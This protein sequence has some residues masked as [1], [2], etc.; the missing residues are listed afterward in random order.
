MKRFLTKRLPACLLALLL[1]VSLAPGA[2]AITGVNVGWTADETHHWQVGNNG[3]RDQYGEHN[4][5]NT[6]T[7]TQE[8]TCFQPGSGTKE[9]TVCGGSVTITLGADPTLHSQDNSRYAHDRTS[10]W[11][12]CEN[13][14]KGCTHRFAETA[15]S[16][17]SGQY[18]AE[19][20]GAVHWQIC[21]TCGERFNEESHLDTS[22]KD[23]IC[24][25][26][27]RTIPGYKPA[28]VSVSFI[29]S[30]AVFNSQTVASGS[31]PAN[32]GTPTKTAA[33]CTYTFRG[34]TTVDPGASA[35]Y[36]NQPLASA[37]GTALSANTTY[38]A[39][40]TLN[41]TGQ[42]DSIGAGTTNGKLIG[43]DIRSHVATRFSA[44][45]GQN[46][47]ASIRFTSS[48]GNGTLYSTSTSRLPV[49]SGSYSYNDLSNYIYYIP[50]SSGSL[51]L[52][53]TA[54]DAYDNQIS[55][56]LTLSAST[57]A[58]ASLITYY[59]APGGTVNFKLTDFQRAYQ[60]LSGGSGLPRYV[61]FSAG[62]DYDN[63]AGRIY[64]GS[65]SM[66]RDRVNSWIFYLEDSRDGDYAL[67]TLNFKADTNARENSELELTYRI[68]Y[69]S[70]VYYDGTLRIVIDHKAVE[71]DVVYRVAPGDSI[72]FNR[73]DF[74]NAYQD[75]TG[76]SRTIRYVTFDPSNLYTNFS[77]KISAA[78]HAD[79]SRTELSREQ[80]N[81]SG[82]SY[83][84]YALDDLRFRA[85]ASA[86]DGDSL[87]IDFRA[88]YS[89]DDYAQGTL[90]IVIDKYG[91]ED[92]VTYNVAPGGTVR[93]DRADFNR[94][95]RAL[96]GTNNR[97]ITAVAFDAPNTYRSFPGKLYTGR[98]TILEQ[99]ELT[100]SRTWFYY[101]DNRDGDF[102]LEDVTFQAERDA[103][104]GSSISIP[105]RAYY[106]D[107]DTYEEGTLRINITTAGSGVTY[108][109]VPGGTVTFRAEDFNEAYRT[110]SGNSGRT[111]KYIA[112]EANSDYA[113]FPGDM[114]TTNTP[115]TRSSLTYTQTQFYY[116]NTAYGA[117]PINS[118]SF[119][120]NANAQNQAT[121]SIPF[122][123]YFDSNSYE[124]STLKIVVDPRANGDI[125]CTVNPGSTVNLDRTKFNDFYRKTY[126]NDTFSYVVFEVPTTSDFASSAGTLYTGYG[127][128]YS[129]SLAR[130]NLQDL[131]FYYNSADAR[132]GDYALNDLTFAAASSFTTGRV[133]L[134][135]TAYGAAG[136]SVE[137]T[138][139]ITPTAA[140][141]SSSYV[142]SIRYSVASGTNVQLNAN[143]LARFYQATY[144]NDTL[145]YVSFT[146]VPAV[147]GLY[148]NYYGA[149]SYGSAAQEQ[150]TVANRAA[151]T[152]YMS[153]TSPTQYALTELAYVPT[154]ANYCASIPFT[155]YGTANRSVTGAILI[156]VTS[157]A[158]SEV[159]G[160]TPK[161]V[162]VNFPASSIYAAVSAASGSALSGI[163][164][165][166]LPSASVGVIYAG[167]GNVPANTSTVYGY[168]SGTQQ[169]G[170][171]RFVPAANYTGSVEIPYVALNANGT[172]IASGVFSLGV[173][174]SNKGFHDVT[175]TTWC[176][177]YVMELSDASVIDGYANGKFQP[178][179]TITYG[180]ALKLIMLAAGYPEQA[181]TDNSS[182][183]SGY[184]ARA[185]ADGLI[186]RSNINLSTPITR[187][188]VAQLAAG[189]LKL[190]IEHLS[191]VKPFTDTA[192][193][194]VQALNAAGIVEG[195]F[196]NG[197]STFRPNN[198]L[199]RGQVSAIVWR[200]RNFRR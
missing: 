6:I 67:N 72:T 18:T 31:A 187:L 129:A 198:T 170:Q 56:V 81:Y 186:T 54:V 12:P 137:G 197:T 75:I 89:A 38:Y 104:D 21:S 136:R 150:I 157:R 102:A 83:G 178:D 16:A 87:E 5:S 29:N 57:T 156:S 95:Y 165:L 173:L 179:S 13:A 168:N 39:V 112:F 151:R 46:S 47:F 94:V 134:R 64:S 59:A 15:H 97:T 153:P 48:S 164:L 169:M 8:P 86:K 158:V 184:L 108:S 85:T 175:A 177:K 166:K 49:G 19:A 91:S 145:Q 127:T 36:R 111:I 189:A 99:A 79:F 196:S 73:S 128:S 174:N 78:G 146:D 30:G 182:V 107:A 24:D 126:A 33:N 14:A 98:N 147:G 103:K 120:V 92:T 125:T 123:A 51:S 115:L 43:G 135:F 61:T 119:R 90:R 93:F 55:G 17:P 190:D 121:L 110:I 40:Y 162:A 70:S 100:Y 159:Y 26:C 124:E 9:C 113:S 58:N 155:A 63:F 163:Q 176:Y 132:N 76:S 27:G 11:R 117:Y 181:P 200:M 171:L 131:R 105:F 20:N 180:A 149:S 141:S 50:A 44:L 69:N 88:Y 28:T 2:L 154:G 45:T 142:G 96:S 10:H 77:G 82:T 139:V 25:R 183:F 7:V 52:N 106:N 62:K 148:Y 114:Y 152:F 160:V 116:D 84:D 34:W 66:D 193:V 138:L 195:Y 130:S 3:A 192:D 122:R 42:N 188:Q 4:F 161:G 53:Y 199:T 143:D 22:P 80:F 140:S 32:P 118:L 23:G 71:G 191:S 167:T 185:R 1:T 68:Y 37:T 194:Y 109:V 133:T 60:S 74:N 144:S 65:R 101:S 35:V 172:A 41:A